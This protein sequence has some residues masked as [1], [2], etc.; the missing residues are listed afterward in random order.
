MQ[1]EDLKTSFVIN[2]SMIRRRKSAPGSWGAYFVAFAVLLCYFKTA[3]L[4]SYGLQGLVAVVV[5]A[6]VLSLCTPLQTKFVSWAIP[7]FMTGADKQ[8][9]NIKAVLTQ[10]LSGRVLDVGAASGIWLPYYNNGKVTAVTLLEPNPY[11]AE[12][13][14]ELVKEKRSF[15]LEAVC[16]V[17]SSLG[18]EYDGAFDSVVLGNV[19]CE[20][21]NQEEALREVDRVLK[22]GGRVYFMEH[23]LH[24][25]QGS[26]RE[27]LQATLQNAI[28]WWWVVV[29][30]GCN[31]NRDC[32]P[33]F[34]SMG[35]DL[36]HQAIEWNSIPHLSKLEVGIAEKP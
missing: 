28:N 4:I 27:R 14:K 11:M 26:S 32:I 18:K 23:V 3:N 6:Y 5:G 36:V 33:V 2:E 35:W 8:M 15:Q 9:K 22:P 29:S 7:L 34:Q 24:D 30:G 13:L 12:D 21:P 17:L 10:T 1:F 25:R 16:G 19:L 31:C 20:V